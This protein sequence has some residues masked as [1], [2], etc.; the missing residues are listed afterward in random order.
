MCGL[1]ATCMPCLYAHIDFI[2]W[3][4][5]GPMALTQYQILQYE[6][7]PRQEQSSHGPRREM[8]FFHDTQPT[9]ERPK[10]A[11]RK[12][13]NNARS[14]QQLANGRRVCVI[15]GIRNKLRWR[16]SAS[17]SRAGSDKQSR[18]CIVT[19]TIPYTPICYPRQRQED[20]GIDDKDKQALR[21][22][23]RPAAAQRG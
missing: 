21:N 12:G 6:I 5:I 22:P 13:P 10:G 16:A 23:S 7:L 3:P 18:G 1:K 9:A 2:P 14:L 17:V 20:E 8:P 4:R 15:S 19:Y 11:N